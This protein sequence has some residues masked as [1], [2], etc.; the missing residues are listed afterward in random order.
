MALRTSDNEKSGRANTEPNFPKISQ[1]YRFF[2]EQ[3]GP[4]GSIVDVG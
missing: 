1:L 2:L 3:N 4:D